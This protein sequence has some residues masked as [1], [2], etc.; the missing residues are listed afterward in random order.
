MDIFERLGY[1]DNIKP[2]GK[3]IT[4]TQL[5]IQGELGRTDRELLTEKVEDIRL[6]YVFNKFTY[7]MAEVVTE[8]ECYDAIFI[9]KVILRTDVSLNKLSKIIQA[10]L[11]TPTV[12]LFKKN[13]EYFFSSALKRLN[14]TEK[15]KTVAEEIVPG[16]GSAVAVNDKIHVPEHDGDV[17]DIGMQGFVLSENIDQIE[18]LVVADPGGIQVSAHGEDLVDGGPALK[19]PGDGVGVA[20]HGLH[21][22]LQPFHACQVG[23]LD[24]AVDDAVGLI[25][26][27]AADHQN[28]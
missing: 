17:V 7:P 18:Q 3:R 1:K 2:Y 15:G 26:S 10:A 25:I 13:D 23:G 14:K 4:K 20:E 16:G 21:S 12:I 8:E 9:V 27:D 22:F 28:G 24:I 11:P 5:F 6:E 19:G